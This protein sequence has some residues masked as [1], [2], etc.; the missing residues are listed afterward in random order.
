VI[1]RPIPTYVCV[2]CQLP[3]IGNIAASLELIT[4]GRSSTWRDRNEPMMMHATLYCCCYCYSREK[5]RRAFCTAT[6]QECL[7]KRA[8][9][10]E[11][12]GDVRRQQTLIQ[13]HH[14]KC[15]LFF[16]FFSKKK[17]KEHNNLP[18]HLPDIP[19]TAAATATA[20]A[21]ATK[22]THYHPC[23]AAA[24]TLATALTRVQKLLG[25]FRAL[26]VCCFICLILSLFSSLF[27]PKLRRD[28][29]QIWV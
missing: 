20:T 19:T 26:F 23:M 29:R 14:C 25:L 7:W 22:H 3:S 6:L 12:D 17:K 18:I 24:T 2:A 15:L 13:L 27:F 5:N 10:H 21:T 1:A 11:E 9:G 28:Q 4:S 8:T 16:L